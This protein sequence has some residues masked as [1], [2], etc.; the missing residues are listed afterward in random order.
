MPETN[1]TRK[2]NS[3]DNHIGVNVKK[4]CDLISLAIV[5]V[6]EKEDHTV[7]KQNDNQW[8]S[9]ATI[10]IGSILGP[11]CSCEDAELIN[12]HLSAIRLGRKLK[13]VL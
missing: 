2:P 5:V 13:T 12:Q 1:F 10:E 7:T 9:R 3:D 11:D 4:L 6:T 8:Y